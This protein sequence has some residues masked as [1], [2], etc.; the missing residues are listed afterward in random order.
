MV[1]DSSSRRRN[2]PRADC[3]SCAQHRPGTRQMR[4]SLGCDGE[5]GGRY[6]SHPH[7]RGRGQGL[8]HASPLSPSGQG[9]RP[10]LECSSRLLRRLVA[11][12]EKSDRYPSRLTTMLT[13]TQ[14]DTGGHKTTSQGAKVGTIRRQW[15]HANVSG[16]N[17]A[18]SK[19]AGCRFDSCPTC[20]FLPHFME[21]QRLNLR[22]LTAVV[23]AVVTAVRAAEALLPCTARCAG[24]EPNT[25]ES[26]YASTYWAPTLGTIASRFK[27]P[28]EHGRP[29]GISLYNGRAQA[30][31]LP[32]G[33]SPVCVLCPPIAYHKEQHR[34][35]RRAA[36]R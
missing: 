23:T 29:H 12:R 13:T 24:L 30:R 21:I 34:R 22:P 33:P 27:C 15:T 28:H 3:A 2:S 4:S 36:F 19:T 20:H 7:R 11:G 17:E 14:G 16:R 35:Y 32:H 8:T 10:L 9:P 5:M 18:N 1:A 6:I 31:L 26:G 25:Y